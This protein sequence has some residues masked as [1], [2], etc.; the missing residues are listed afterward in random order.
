MAQQWQSYGEIGLRLAGCHDLSLVS[1]VLALARIEVV[2][3]QAIADE[4]S[5]SGSGS[6]TG[7]QAGSGSLSGG[8]SASQ[9]RREW[10]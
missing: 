3:E 2:Q 1:Q 6:G 9:S 4:G 8:V 5:G 10:R 7:S